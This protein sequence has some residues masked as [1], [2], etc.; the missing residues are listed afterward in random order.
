MVI[1]L[2]MCDLCKKQEKDMSL[3]S[4]NHEKMGHIWVCQ[5]CWKKLYQENKIICDLTG[6]GGSCSACR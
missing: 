4:A 6:S 5:D 2:N 1:K 3:M